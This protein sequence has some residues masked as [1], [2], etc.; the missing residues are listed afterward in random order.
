MENL[1]LRLDLAPNQ[2]WPV[3]GFQPDLGLDLDQGLKIGPAGQQYGPRSGQGQDP[4]N[5]HGLRPNQEPNP[6]S[7]KGFFYRVTPKVRYGLVLGLYR[8]LG[9]KVL[10]SRVLRFEVL[11]SQVLTLS[12]NIEGQLQWEH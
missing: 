5:L 1:I 6:A 2:C 7:Q 8:V 9:F 12:S 3:S 11:R 4:V 10:G